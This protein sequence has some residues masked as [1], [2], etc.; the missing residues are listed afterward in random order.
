MRS[1]LLG[2]AV[3]I[4]LVLIASWVNYTYA[5]QRHA[6]WREE[7]ERFERGLV[8]SPA[9]SPHLTKADLDK[10]YHNLGFDTGDKERR[11]FD[12]RELAIV[13]I[14]SVGMLLIALSG[15]AAQSFPRR[16]R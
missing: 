3:V 13:I 14:G 8:P 12:E 4:V 15:K 6:F 5:K 11:W 2:I 7:T 9:P 1:R 16:N 10:L